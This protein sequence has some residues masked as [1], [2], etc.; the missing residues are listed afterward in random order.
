V[1]AIKEYTADNNEKEFI[2]EY[3]ALERL[4]RVEH[5]N[6][7][8]AITS[9]KRGRTFFF[10]FPWA[11][12][13]DLSQ[14]WKKKSKEVRDTKMIRWVFEQVK[15]LAS[16]IRRLHQYSD[17]ENGRHGDLKPENILMFLD[18][19]KKP[20]ATLCISDVGLARFHVQITSRRV[21]GTVTTGGT[22]MYAPPEARKEKEVRSRKYDQWSLGCIYL[23]FIIWTLG[24]NDEVERFRKERITDS[25]GHAE[26]YHTHKSW[27]GKSGYRVLPQV[28][29]WMR[30]IGNDPR[31]RGNTAFKDLLKIIQD[32]LLQVEYNARLDADKLE[33]RLDR[34]LDNAK[35]KPSYWCNNADANGGFEPS[36]FSGSKGPFSQP[37]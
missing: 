27:L 25:S 7:I 16:G 36:A 13:G 22:I 20:L 34:I 12:G 18:D 33:N 5:A 11:D 3:E 26:Y 2:Q 9:F 10:L 24:G 31:V 21:T 28:C 4:Q 32:N 8:Q 1:I 19:P 35:N 37:S 23:E 15:G 29:E 6:L 30:T 17:E 14:V